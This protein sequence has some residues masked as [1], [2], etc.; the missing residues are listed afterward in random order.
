ME[1]VEGTQWRFGQADQRPESSASQAK[2]LNRATPLED[3]LLTNARR[4]AIDAPSAAQANSA[5]ELFASAYGNHGPSADSV[6]WTKGLVAAGD[7]WAQA[8]LVNASMPS[9]A[10]HAGLPIN[11]V[12]ETSR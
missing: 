8:L 12:A 10:A 7:A 4:P 11:D 9:V 1:P 5:V 2:Y 6:A 3:A